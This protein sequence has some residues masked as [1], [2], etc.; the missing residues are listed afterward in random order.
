V[1]V[2][3][4]D[5]ARAALLAALLAAGPLV[6]AAGPALAVD[7]PARP[8][9]HVTHG[10][11]CAAGGVVVEVTAGTVPYSVVLATTRQPA[12]EER[13]ELAAGATVTLSTGDVDWGETVDSRLEYAALD[14]SGVA[15]V[16]ELDDW[17]MTR[18]S[19]QD[20]AAVAPP[21]GVE[22]LTPAP[23]TPVATTEPPAP[24]AS[25]TPTTPATPSAVPP[26]AAPAPTSAGGAPTPGVTPT[27]VPAG[28]VTADTEAIVP[29]ALVTVRGT[30]FGP[31]ERVGVGLHGLDVELASATAGADGVVD[32][33]VR[34]PEGVPA[35]AA[36]LDLV[37]D[38]TAARVGVPV[39]VAASVS[40]A[41]DPGTPVGPAVVAVSAVV[42]LTAAGGAG[43]AVLRRRTRG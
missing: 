5:A 6:L 14:G 26:T 39:Q 9:A 23:P 38:R 37:G 10:P 12:G 21:S 27:A 1:P 24:S 17:T 25:P 2:A 16:D 4:W 32:L 43:I 18:P 7:D 8:D 11:S 41:P 33:V 31:G 40:P 15:Y 29:G 34:I 36:T 42:V 13:A 19:Q 20:C 22:P 3:P 28:T 30:G 35:G